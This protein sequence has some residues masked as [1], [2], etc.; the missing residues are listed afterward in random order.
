MQRYVMDTA[1]DTPLRHSLYECIPSELSL[2]SELDNVEMPTMNISILC[3]GRKDQWQIFK[4]RVVAVCDLL[5]PT[6]KLPH[7]LELVNTQ[8]G[9][10]IR[11]VVLEP[12]SYNVV[13]PCGLL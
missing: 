6:L 9:G 8:R 10:D 2:C 4:L 1:T 13:M 3:F 7:L 12:R 5:S 11:H